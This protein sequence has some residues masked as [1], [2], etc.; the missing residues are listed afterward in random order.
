LK[1]PSAVGFQH[2]NRPERR[3]LEASR[4]GLI[5]I[6]SGVENEFEAMALAEPD[7][8]PV[9][10]P[11]AIDP[12]VIHECP[13][14][15]LQIAQNIAAGIPQYLRVKPRYI[16][17][18]EGQVVFFETADSRYSGIQLENPGPAFVVTVCQKG[19]S[20]HWTPPIDTL[21]ITSGS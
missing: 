18:V 20:R 9:S 4:L 15:A 1:E 21:G 7:S 13:R 10:K 3:S 16:R 11:L 8:V 19:A 6:N 2:S 17:I 14:R 12:N 5:A